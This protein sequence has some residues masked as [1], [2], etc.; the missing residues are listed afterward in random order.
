MANS[1]F[2]ALAAG[3]VAL[4]LSALATPVDLSG[5]VP[6]HLTASA[7]KIRWV[8]CTT[9]VPE[10]LQSIALPTALPTNLHCGLLT[11]PM[12]YSKSI[13]SSNNITLAFAMR[14]PENP[15]GLLNL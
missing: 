7:Q 8:N 12:D 4:T 6:G 14:R 9:C 15:Q 1:R 13:S 3:L 11:V 5:R 10:P 2:I